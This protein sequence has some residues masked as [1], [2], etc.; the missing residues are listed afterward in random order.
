MT[1][2]RTVEVGTSFECKIEQA[3]SEL[4]YIATLPSR[5]WAHWL[6]P[7][8]LSM[9]KRDIVINLLWEA[10][11]GARDELGSTAFLDVGDLTTASKLLAAW[12][13][14]GRAYAL[15][16]RFVPGDHYHCLDTKHD[17]LSEAIEHIRRKGRVFGGIMEK[18]LPAN[19]R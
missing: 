16:S 19:W 1:A 15:V 13:V 12:R 14:Q 17:T 2:I 6:R 10:T 7:E 4:R 11:D 3:E 18:H 8:P 9:A 5:F